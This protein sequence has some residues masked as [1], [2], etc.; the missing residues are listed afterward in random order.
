MPY[1]PPNFKSSMCWRGKLLLK[2]I[3]NVYFK[4]YLMVVCLFCICIFHTDVAAHRGQKNALEP[5]GAKVTDDCKW[6][7]VGTVTQIQVLRD[8]SKHS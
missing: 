7:D 6:L 2:I 4:N 3:C 5:H 8:S 1:L